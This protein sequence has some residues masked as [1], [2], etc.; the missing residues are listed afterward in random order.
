MWNLLQPSVPLRI[1]IESN[2][3]I[4]IISYIQLSA[5]KTAETALDYFSIGIAAISGFLT[6]TVPFYLLYKIL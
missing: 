6:V 3:V 2:F 1:F 5:I 4:L